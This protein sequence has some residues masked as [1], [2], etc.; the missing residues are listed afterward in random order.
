[1]D[2]VMA[3]TVL[4]YEGQARDAWGELVI[5]AG[6]VNVAPGRWAPGHGSLTLLTLAEAVERLVAEAREVSTRDTPSQ[7]LAALLEDLRA[8]AAETEEAATRDREH[9]HTDHADALDRCAGAT[10]ALIARHE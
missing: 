7:R 8:D 6:W 4:S 3:A 5:A 9:G 2:A 10:R 1:M